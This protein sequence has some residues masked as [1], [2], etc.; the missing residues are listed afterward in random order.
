MT[1]A[2]ENSISSGDVSQVSEIIDYIKNRKSRLKNDLGA[3]ELLAI[4]E[5]VSSKAAES[6]YILRNGGCTRHSRIGF[7][8]FYRW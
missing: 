6:T 4:T 5:F 8:N 2:I 3:K 7:V 1:E